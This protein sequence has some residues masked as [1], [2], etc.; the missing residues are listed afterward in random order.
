MKKRFDLFLQLF[1]MAS[2]D[3]LISIPEKKLQI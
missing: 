1:E 3:S 2:V